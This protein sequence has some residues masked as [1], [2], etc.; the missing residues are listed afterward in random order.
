MAILDPRVLELIE[1]LVAARLDWLAFELI[2][3]I[4]LGRLPDEPEEVLAAARQSVRSN[5][6]P[7][8]RGEPRAL[9][10]EPKPI[11]A[12]EQVEWAAAYVEERLDAALEQLQAS[13]ETLDF[14][15]E[16]T[17]ER[18]DPQDV[19]TQASGKTDQGVTLVLL[20]LE[21][22]RKSSRDDVAGAR[23]D[24]FTLH[25]ALAEWTALSR[26]QATT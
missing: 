4:R 14:I 10:D 1:T 22:D 23:G 16:G 7:K 20:D 6:Q 12:G 2:E 19:P 13:L 26:G 25:A 17:I 18:Q 3:G 15:V 5:A 8:A 9:L 21:G 24:F 11:P